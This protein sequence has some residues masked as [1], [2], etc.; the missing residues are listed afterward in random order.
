MDP[1]GPIQEGI[2][3]DG[4]HRQICQFSSGD[5]AQYKLVLQNIKSIMAPEPDGSSQQDYNSNGKH[6]Q[7]T[8]RSVTKIDRSK[9]VQHFITAAISFGPLAATDRRD[10]SM[11]L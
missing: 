1:V 3:L 6:V 11:G 2:S 9:S 4:D 8:I 10:M 5:D 7:D